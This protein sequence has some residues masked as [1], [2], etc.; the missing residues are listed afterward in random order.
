MGT[1]LHL[2]VAGGVAL[3]PLA[4]AGNALAATPQLFVSGPPGTAMSGEAVVELRED[5]SDAAPSKITVYV[6]SGYLLNVSHAAGSR[7]GDLTA[8]VQALE[9]SPDTVVDIRDGSVLVADRDSADLA[10][11]ATR[12][13]GNAKHDAIWILSLIHI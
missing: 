2:L 9:Q 10:A 3:A 5:K 8:S 13:T 7:I 11:A 6:P 1:R 12:C 4:L